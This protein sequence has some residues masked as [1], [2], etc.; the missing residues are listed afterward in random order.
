MS[1]TAKLIINNLEY[2][3]CLID[4]DSPNFI[5][6]DGVIRYY[7]AI[8]NELGKIYISSSLKSGLLLRTI[9]CEV[10]HAYLYAYGFVD[11]DYYSEYELR[12][13]IASYSQY[14][15]DDSNHIYN[16]LNGKSDGSDET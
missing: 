8:S 3:V 13:F 6:T 10:T 14:I 2:E 4:R 11:I 9:I 1:N 12:N 7:G 5:A 15:L 16:C